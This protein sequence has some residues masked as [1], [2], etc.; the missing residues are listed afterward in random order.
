MPVGNQPSWEQLNQQAAQLIINAREAL[1]DI[2]FFNLYLQS[3]GQAG[4]QAAPFNA[5][6]ADA[7]TLISVFGGLNAVAS[8]CN[9]GPAPSNV[10]NNFLAETAP[11]W[12]GN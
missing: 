1:Q 7:E 4:L 6:A 12:G 2:L 9:G 11:F 5:S 8:M 3:L 10:P